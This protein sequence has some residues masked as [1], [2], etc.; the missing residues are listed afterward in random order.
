MKSKITYKQNCVCFNN[1]QFNEIMQKIL[2][3]LVQ[4]GSI[5]HRK[6][7]WVKL[8]FV[9]ISI[10]YPNGNTNYQADSQIYISGD[11]KRRQCSRLRFSTSVVLNGITLLN[12]YTKRKRQIQ[13]KC[14]ETFQHLELRGQE[15]DQRVTQQN[16][17]SMKAKEDLVFRRTL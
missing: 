10:R 11:L 8:Y 3:S 13:G 9:V 7:V 5:W 14:L 15:R 6:K 4:C 17:I 12:L 16:F 1:V 2:E